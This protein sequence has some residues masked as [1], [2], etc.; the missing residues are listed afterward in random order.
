VQAAAVLS[1]AFPEPCWLVSGS[2]ASILARLADAEVVGGS[3]YD[4]L[5]GLAAGDNVMTL[6]TRDRRAQRTCDA[7][8]VEY[9]FVT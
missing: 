5:V 9:Q 6:L 2:A 1:D 8:H 4:A 7:M 3:V